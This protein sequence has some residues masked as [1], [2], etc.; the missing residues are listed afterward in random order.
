MP[1]RL[2]EFARTIFRCSMLWVLM[3]LNPVALADPR[4]NDS[5]RLQEL[6][7]GEALFH[8]QQQDYFSAI[9]QLQLADEQGTLPSSSTDSAILLARLKLAYGLDIDAANNFLFKKYS[10]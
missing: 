6:L 3:L 10:W 4:E 1:D 2:P 5:G 8:F 9:T 7:Y